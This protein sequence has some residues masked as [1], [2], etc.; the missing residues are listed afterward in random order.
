MSRRQH[1]GESRP[2]AT[3]SHLILQT[4]VAAAAFAVPI[5]FQLHGE[6][7][8]R[9]P[10]DIVFRVAAIAVAAA[11]VSGTILGQ[12]DWSA[13]RRRRGLIA[14]LSATTSWMVITTLASTNR[15]ASMAASVHLM[16]AL[17][18]F[19]GTFIAFTSFRNRLIVLAISAG[20]IC[21][22]VLATLQALGWLQPF[23]LP[24]DSTGRLAVTG[25]M[26]N[27]SDVGS[28]LAI[29]LVAA[30]AWA[31]A[32]RS[33]QAWIAA[34]ILTAGLVST[35]SLTAVGAVIAGG[36][37]LAAVARW[38][39]RAGIIAIALSAAIILC[40]GL[41]LVWSRVTIKA[42]RAT[43]GNYHAVLSFRVVPIATALSMFKERPLL[44]LGP[45]TFRWHYLPYRLRLEQAHPEY[46][47]TNV[48]NYGEAHSDHV[49]ILAETGLPGYAIFLW[50]LSMIAASGVRSF[51]PKVQHS[52][53]A[54]IAQ[55]GG[56]PLAVTIAVLALGFFPL[57]LST[58]ATALALVVAPALRW[59]DVES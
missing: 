6:D 17:V 5:A 15:A 2:R 10:K 43:E 18:L 13:L 53:A 33:W 40:A 35:Q 25:F 41:L 21:N 52:E 49:Q 9:L 59:V 28:Y 27:P 4:A 19:I 47:L 32:R 26:G 46:Y 34:T 37:T 31:M 54:T 12:I 11:L 58:S 44:G 57:M 45:G 23:T 38:R 16:C 48:Q 30:I 50:W 24:D 39:T 42:V 36:A 29:F 8:F 1:V 51:R 20:A 56:A 22:A 3:L 7:R 14:L 55:L